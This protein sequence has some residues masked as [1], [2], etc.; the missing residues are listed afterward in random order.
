MEN[1]QRIHA[2][3]LTTATVKQ[4]LQSLVLSVLLFRALPQGSSGRMERGRK[5]FVAAS[6]DFAFN[7][8]AS[9]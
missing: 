5:P 4:E 2:V 1:V 7:L 3:P 6:L 9:L 8:I